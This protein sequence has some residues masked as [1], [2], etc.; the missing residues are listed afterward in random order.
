MPIRAEAGGVGATDNQA[1]T[2][3]DA[4]LLKYLT[5]PYRQKYRQNVM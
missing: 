3:M 1:A 5:L 4:R 2:R